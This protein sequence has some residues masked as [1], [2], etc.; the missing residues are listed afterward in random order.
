MTRNFLRNRK[1]KC[2]RLRMLTRF[3]EKGT[4]HCI[5]SVDTMFPVSYIHI[6]PAVKCESGFSVGFAKTNNVQKE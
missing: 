5:I 1:I 3:P 6:Q 4:R 2:L